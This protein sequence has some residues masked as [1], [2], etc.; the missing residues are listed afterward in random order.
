M[1]LKI[2]DIF[3]YPNWTHSRAHF[4]FAFFTIFPRALTFVPLFLLFSYLHQTDVSFLPIFCGYFN[5]WLNSVRLSICAL[6]ATSPLERKKRKGKMVRGKP[7]LIG[8]C[9]SVCIDWASLV[10]LPGLT[11]SPVHTLGAFCLVGA[12]GAWEMGHA[13]L[14]I[15]DRLP[16]LYRHYYFAFDLLPLIAHSKWAPKLWSSR[17]C[18]SQLRV[19]RY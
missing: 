18:T 17:G 9:V 19:W 4:P 12:C 7:V 5:I 6:L 16:L 11:C 14:L 15:Q 1:C 8:L 10:P 3:K 13:S 2:N